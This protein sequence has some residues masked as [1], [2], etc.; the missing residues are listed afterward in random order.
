[1]LTHILV[2]VDGSDHALHALAYAKNLLLSLKD[3]PRLTV[4]HVNPDVTINEPPVGVEL[5]EQIEAE[6]SRL[7]V[8]VQE[9][10]ADLQSDYNTLVKHGDPG[11][12]IC[13]T[14]AQEMA[15]L[16]VMG[17]RGIGLISE[18]L[19]GSVSHYV[20]QH[21]ACPVLTTK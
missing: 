21:A 9:L 16:I 12:I 18:L 3:S 8:P 14:A 4:L 15:D 10:L 19:I 1:M 17:T 20:I 13:Q 5:D 6:G 11:K 2:P 7:L